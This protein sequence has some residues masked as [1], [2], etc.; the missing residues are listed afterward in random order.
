MKQRTVISLVL[1]LFCTLSV[2]QAKAK[3]A[4]EVFDAVSPSLVVVKAYDAKGNNLTQGSG[5]ALTGNELVTNCHVVKSGH[6]YQIVYLD[7][8]YA[9]KLKFS[10]WERDVCSLTAVGLNAMPAILGATGKLKVGQRVYAVGAPN[11]LTLTL[12]DGLVSNLRPVDGGQYLQITA[13]ISPG[14]SGG[15]LFDDEGR[16]IGL[17]TFYLTEGQ[18]LN[19][20]VPVEWIK[21]L[22]NRHQVAKNSQPITNRIN[23]AAALEEKKDWSGLRQ[24]ALSW[25]K[26]TP[27]HAVSWSILGIAYS[28][29]NQTDEEIEA[30]QQAILINPEYAGAWYNLGGAYG[31]SGQNDKEI[32]AYQRAILINSE[33]A[34]VWNNLGYAYGKSGQTAKAITAFQQAIRINPEYTEA[35]YNLGS[36][37]CKLEQPDK[38]IEVYKLLKTLDPAMA[39]DFF[40]K[41]VLP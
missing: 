31:K 28:K 37:Y 20:A 38:M 12:S 10:D 23:K 27:E 15:G 7:K 26:A 34:E 18:Q 24:Y 40:N 3:S 8:T 29:L 30:Y 14:S 36:V 4:S 6:H 41:I 1:G 19:F 22:P 9:A 5:V 17:P 35:W 13:P 11:G 2:V 32:D 25:T 21:K 33:Y 39:A 16:L